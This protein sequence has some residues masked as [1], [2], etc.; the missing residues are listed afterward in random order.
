ME[1]TQST[2]ILSISNVKSINMLQ[3]LMLICNTNSKKTLSSDKI[4]DNWYK[5]NSLVNSL[6]E[7]C[8]DI[9]VRKKCTIKIEKSYPSNY[10]QLQNNISK[11][12]PGSLIRMCISGSSLPR[13]DNSKMENDIMGKLI[14]EKNIYELP[15]RILL[16]KN[17]KFFLDQTVR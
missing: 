16:N 11:K 14:G 17:Q 10:I 7:K 5:V 1:R 9:S 13:K 2:R 15:E 4:Y 6:L 12:I 8:H 3:T